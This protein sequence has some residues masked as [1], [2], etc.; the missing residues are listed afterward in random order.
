M[1][2]TIFPVEWCKHCT[3]TPY[4]Q[5]IVFRDVKKKPPEKI[6]AEA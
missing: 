5:I 3:E 4:T 6:I 2:Q 1:D